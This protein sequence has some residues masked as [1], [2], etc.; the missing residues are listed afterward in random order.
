MAFCPSVFDQDIAPLDKAGIAK[1]LSKS[2]SKRRIFPSG[3]A[4][5]ESNDRHHRLLRARRERPRGRP[6]AE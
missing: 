4:I 6:A 2:G 3:C 5:E 1:T